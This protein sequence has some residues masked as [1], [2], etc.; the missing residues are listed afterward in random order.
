MRYSI[1]MNGQ[2]IRE[3]RKLLRYNQQKFATELGVGI[4]T[5]HRWEAGKARPSPLAVGRLMI[6]EAQ[7]ES[8]QSAVR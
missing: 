8:S 6:L 4:A 5:V 2:Q 7:F 1:G 3:L